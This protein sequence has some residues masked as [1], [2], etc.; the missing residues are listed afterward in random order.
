MSSQVADANTGKQQRLIMKSESLTF[1]DDGT[2]Y[3]ALLAKHSSQDI[4]SGFTCSPQAKGVV[5]KD[6]CTRVVLDKT[7]DKEEISDVT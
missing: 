3:S 2:S 7:E 5:A 4:T 1:G 6:S